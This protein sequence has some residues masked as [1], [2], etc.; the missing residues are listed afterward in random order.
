MHKVITIGG[1]SRMPKIKALL[2]QHFNNIPIDQ[3][4]NNDETIAYGAA[5]QAAAYTHVKDETIENMVHIYV[6]PFS[7]GIETNGGKMTPLLPRNSAIPVEKTQNFSTFADNQSSVLIQ[8]YEGENELT[9]QNNLIGKFSLEGIPP[10]PKGK[11]QI[12]VTFSLDEKYN[13]IVS[14]N[15]KVIGI[16]NKMIMNYQSKKLITREKLI[17]LTNKLKREGKSEKEILEMICKDLKIKSDEIL[18]WIKNNKNLSN[19][20]IITKKKEL[21]NLLD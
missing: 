19:G 10:M 12:E 11:P 9:S 20:E 18:E 4:I 2:Q 16:S 7:I 13:L 5:I 14:A 6:S 17:K 21:Y 15:E 3:S 8:V 1:S